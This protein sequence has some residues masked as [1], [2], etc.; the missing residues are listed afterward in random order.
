MDELVQIMFKKANSGPPPPPTQTRAQRQQQLQYPLSTAICCIHLHDNNKIRLVNAPSSLV[1]LLRQAIA[2]TWNEPIQAESRLGYLKGG[3]GGVYEFRFNGKPWAPSPKT[4]PF[5]ASTNLVLAMKKAMETRGWSLVL[6]S[7][8]SRVREENDSLFFEWR[9][10]KAGSWLPS[11]QS[12]E[13]DPDEMTLVGEVEQKNKY[14]YKNGDQNQEREQRLSEEGGVDMLNIELSGIE[15][16]GDMKGVHEFTLTGCPFQTWGAETTIE[17]SM[18]IIQVF[19]NMRL[20][21]FKLVEL[22]DLDVIGKAEKQ[23]VKE[24]KKKVKKEKVIID[25]W[26][27]R[28]TQQ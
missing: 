3:D 28:R 5:I 7:N 11:A 27:L 20:H 9:E 24:K 12:R 22:T 16:E 21:R 4:G 10:P 1:P 25:S 14:D 17:V 26:V 23:E 15:K 6:A 8:V 2:S 18:M 19:V 13:R